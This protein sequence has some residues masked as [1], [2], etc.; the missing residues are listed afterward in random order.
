[1]SLSQLWAIMSGNP[2]N[3]IPTDGLKEKR[4]ILEFFNICVIPWNSTPRY[5]VMVNIHIWM[6]TE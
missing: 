1:M 5:E 2:L 4:N 3:N 6:E